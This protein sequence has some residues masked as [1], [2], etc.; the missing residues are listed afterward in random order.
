MSHTD[1]HTPQTHT[2]AK[3][4]LPSPIFADEESHRRSRESWPAVITAMA[5]TVEEPSHASHL[6]ERQ[7]SS[8]PFDWRP[9]LT[10]QKSQRERSPDSQPQLTHCSTL[11]MT[12]SVTAQSTSSLSTGVLRSSSSPHST[13]AAD[14]RHL[15]R[16]H[17]SRTSHVGLIC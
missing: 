13:S 15:T 4:L 3:R 1:T 7:L 14:T 8:C 2:H 11:K 10:K 16:R 17:L 6:L 5:L 9:H 12:P